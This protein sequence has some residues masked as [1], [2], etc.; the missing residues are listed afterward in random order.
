MMPDLEPRPVPRVET[1][2]RRIV[3][4]IPVPESIPILRRLRQFE[5]RSMG[6]Q[7]PVVWDRAEGYQVYDRWGNMWLDWSSGVL[8]T[9][10]GHSHPR[11]S[12]AM[13]DQIE[14]G[15]THNYCFPSAVRAELVAELA[16]AARRA[17]RRC[18]S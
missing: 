8:V 16:C 4:P 2:Y 14:H 15:L 6:G 5:P 11:I 9:N 17:C 7:P 1:K 13:V 10:A 3:T 12:R 18:S